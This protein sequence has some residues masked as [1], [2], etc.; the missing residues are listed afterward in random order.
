MAR[1]AED[2]PAVV[3]QSI[4][5]SNN[6]R[7][8]VI[9][10]EDAARVQLAKV[11]EG[12]IESL[13]GKLEDLW[14][15]SNV[16]KARNQERLAETTRILVQMDAQTKNLVNFLEDHEGFCKAYVSDLIWRSSRRV[17]YGIV[18]GLLT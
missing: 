9:L 6:I 13:I 15:P 7:I 8:P 4:R 3:P 10:G 1:K 18:P 5:P 14:M 17:L 16:S 12:D 2:R 11:I